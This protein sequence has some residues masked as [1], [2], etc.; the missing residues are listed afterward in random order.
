LP[1]KITSSSIHVTL[2]AANRRA[3][4]GLIAERHSESSPLRGETHAT[5]GNGNIRCVNRDVTSSFAAD[6][7]LISHAWFNINHTRFNDERHSKFSYGIFTRRNGRW[8]AHTQAEAMPHAAE[9]ERQAG[10]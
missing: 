9:L 3:P 2:V 4:N 5:P 1:K 6:I 8:F 7:N 10:S